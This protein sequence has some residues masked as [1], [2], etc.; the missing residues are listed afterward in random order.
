[1]KYLENRAIVLSIGWSE[2]SNTQ[3]GMKLRQSPTK[4][5]YG[6]LGRAAILAYVPAVKVWV[7]FQAI[8][9]RSGRPKI[10]T[11]QALENSLYTQKSF[12]E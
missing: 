7:V 3:E 10:R 8:C 4:R 12:R 9:F 1:M 11:T 2:S 5:W 6:L